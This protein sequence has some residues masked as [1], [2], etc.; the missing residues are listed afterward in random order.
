MTPTSTSK[1]PYDVALSFAGEDRALAEAIATE[2][3]GLGLTVFYDD[4]ERSS[5]L[6]K[7]LYQHLDAIYRKHAA[8][9]LV[10]ISEH[11]ATRRWPRH[12]LRSAQ[13][14]AFEEGREYIL[15]IRVD[16]TEIP[17]ILPTTGF[18]D[19]RRFTPR[20]IAALVLEKV[21]TLKGHT[22]P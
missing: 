12:E 3:K 16:D 11:Y 4:D 14:R 2:L 1:W 20:E 18:L 9:T 8:F 13:A 10:L 17:G 15:P 7:D 22:P 21:S 5:L 6:G 19:A